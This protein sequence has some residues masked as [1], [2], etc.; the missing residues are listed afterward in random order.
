[1]EWNWIVWFCFFPTV[2]QAFLVSLSIL[3]PSLFLRIVVLYSGVSTRL[4]NS[5]ATV[6]GILVLWWFYS[7][8]LAYF[9]LLCA[10]VYPLL[11][12]PN[13]K[14]GAVVVFACVAFIILW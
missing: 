3:G 7:A 4:V 8:S 10:I 2:Q 13:Q 14:K 5:I 12:M 9:I 11:L 6:L 1:M